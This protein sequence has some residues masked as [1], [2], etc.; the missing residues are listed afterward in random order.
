MKIFVR[1]SFSTTRQLGELGEVEEAHDVKE[2]KRCLDPNQT[3]STSGDS[4]W[5]ERGSDDEKRGGRNEQ[6]M[7]IRIWLAVSL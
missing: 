2:K 6:A 5:E 3:T 7:W 1:R 4:T